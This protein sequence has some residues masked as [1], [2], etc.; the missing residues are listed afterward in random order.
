[1]LNVVISTIILIPEFLT[2]LHSF[3]IFVHYLSNQCEIQVNTRLVSQ[4]LAALS[5]CFVVVGLTQ[6]E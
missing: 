3:S 1:M 6:Q 4:S 2:S 5:K